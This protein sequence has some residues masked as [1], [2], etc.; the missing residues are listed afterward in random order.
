MSKKE[1]VRITGSAFQEKNYK[2][3][4][5]CLKATNSLLHQYRTASNTENVN[6]ELAFIL[7]HLSGPLR[8]EFKVNIFIYIY[9]LNI[10]LF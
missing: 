7:K 3:V 10:I 8:D 4:I 1:L 2:K 6:I 9:I 5:D